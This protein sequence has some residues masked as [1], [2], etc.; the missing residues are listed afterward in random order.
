M[1]TENQYP[2]LA[3]QEKPLKLLYHYLFF[4]QLAD[5]WRRTLGLNR[6]GERFETSELSS[7]RYVR[8][9]VNW[10][11]EETFLG[12][13]VRIL[14]VG[15]SLIEE[16]R[17]IGVVLLGTA[18]FRKK[19]EAHGPNRYIGGELGSVNVIGREVRCVKRIPSPVQ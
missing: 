8:T 11:H 2:D 14:A 16:T 7:P 5:G 10:L 9:A 15:N 19:I 17:E 12:A 4:R 18:T 3:E 1:T 13:Q 6:P